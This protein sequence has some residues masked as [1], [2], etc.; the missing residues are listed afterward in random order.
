M[1][2]KKSP[3]PKKEK[4]PAKSAAKKEPSEKK[5]KKPAAEKAPAA[6]PKGRGKAAAEPAAKATAPEPTSTPEPAPAVSAAP[7]APAPAPK[8]TAPGKGKPA[9]AP[10]AQ[11]TSGGGPVVL[12]PQELAASWRGTQAPEGATVPAGWRWGQKGGP[13]TDYDR[14][15]A[16]TDAV[17][18]ARGGLGWLEVST[19]HA[20]VFS[21]ELPTVW[22]PT[23][24][25]GVVVRGPEVSGANA[26]Q[27]RDELPL[28]GWKPYLEGVLLKDGRV[29]LFDSAASGAA[30]A[31]DISA[32]DG[33]AVGTPG[34]GTYSVD[35]AHVGHTDYFRLTR[36]AKGQ[37]KPPPPK[38]APP[39]PPPPA[40][41][42]GPQWKTKTVPFAQLPKGPGLEARYSISFPSVAPDG[43]II[44][45]QR[46]KPAE[47]CVV[48]VGRDGSQAPICKPGQLCYATVSA[49]GRSVLGATPDGKLL[50]FPLTADASQATVRFEAGSRVWSIHALSPTRAVIAQGTKVVLLDVS[51][52]TWKVLD[53]VSV[54]PVSIPMIDVLGGGRW[55]LVGRTPKIRLFIVVRDRLRVVQGWNQAEGGIAVHDGRPFLFKAGTHD[56]EEILNL[57]EVYAQLS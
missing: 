22:L 2:T 23:A 9:E 15:L 10:L 44:G 11:T 53:P 36:D 47:A 51:G 12:L 56:F 42:T 45:L 30:D 6:K 16:P 25:G 31:K 26:A 34:P 50:D 8:P 28:T 57:D 19:G 37:E 35:R 38:Q 18:T 7:A 40:K 21:D 14:A 29:F 41:A 27:V 48:R 49:D 20:L 1:A 17:Q 4:A 43:T 55:V 32:G 52:E 24:E 46:G 39:P 33:V 5:A 13:K 3:A 54:A